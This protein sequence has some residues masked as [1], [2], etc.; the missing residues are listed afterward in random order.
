MK[1]EKEIRIFDYKQ[2]DT[3]EQERQVLADAVSAPELLDDAILP[4]VSREFFSTEERQQIW[5]TIVELHNNGE[6]INYVTIHTRHPEAFISE[7]APY[8]A[9]AGLSDTPFHAKRLRDVACIR[10]SYA[11]IA[12]FLDLANHPAVTEEELISQVQ[13]FN[14]VVE[15]AAPLQGEKKLENVL[16]DVNAEIGRTREA[17]R[18]GRSLRITTGFQYLDLYLNGGFKAGQLIIL[19]ARPSVGKTALMLQMAKAAATSGKA[20][21]VFSL[22]MQAVEL[23]ERLIFSTEIVRPYDVNFGLVED[24]PLGRAEARLNPLP[25]YINDF[26]RTLD[27]IISRLT[28]ARK[29]GRCD[30]AFIDYLGL[31]NE[32]LNFGNA[33]LYQA[34]ARITGTLKAV[35]KRLEIP[36]VLL[37]QLNR[38]AARDDREPQLFDLRDSGSIEQDSDVVLMIHPKLKDGHISVFLRKNRGGKKEIEFPFVPNDTYSSFTENLPIALIENGIQAAQAEQAE[39]ED[40]MPGDDTEEPL[41]F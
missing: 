9:D 23:A 29:K 13:A 17:A 31:I 3:A 34:I 33:K 39:A 24:E 38:E 14:K 8:L 26:S 41:P 35:A 4:I 11:A 15:G 5:D 7:I 2:P 16:K 27:D 21:Q 25:F 18:E 19:A 20:V 40:D 36:I 6:S 32:A 30:I 1:R 12:D 37:C 10:R 28:I 22:E